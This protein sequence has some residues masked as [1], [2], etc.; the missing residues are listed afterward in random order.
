MIASSD[1]PFWDEFFLIFVDIQTDREIR[2]RER[3]LTE[4]PPLPQLRGLLKARIEVV[5]IDYE[6][7]SMD[8]HEKLFVQADNRKSGPLQ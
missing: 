1:Q 7:Q 3:P 4:L 8:R 2:G 6:E 5:V